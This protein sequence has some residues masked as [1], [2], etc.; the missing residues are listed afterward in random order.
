M[1]SAEAAATNRCFTIKRAQAVQPRDARPSWRI[2]GQSTRGPMLD[3]IAGSSVSTTATLTSGM[4]MP[5][6]PMLR[7][8]GTGTTTRAS[9][10][11]ATVTPEATTAWP[12]VF[13][14]MI[15]ASSL[16]WPCSRSSRQRDTSS[17]E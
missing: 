13:I 7:R 1:T 8:N 10:L 11:I 15:T 4:N 14:A 9:R 3:S 6:M 16:S 5:P 17:S 12:A 2:F